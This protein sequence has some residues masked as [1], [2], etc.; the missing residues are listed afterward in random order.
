MTDDLYQLKMKSTKIGMI[1][2]LHSL[3]FLTKVKGQVMN[4][5]WFLRSKRKHEGMPKAVATAIMSINQTHDFLIR[6][7]LTADRSL[8]HGF[9][10]ASSHHRRS[11]LPNQVGGASCITALL[12]PANS[13]P[14]Y[15]SWG[16]VDRI[17]C[18]TTSG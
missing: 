1:L 14:R 8:R 9:L 10:T 6:Y 17:M 16:A 5:C 2:G 18:S 4:E 15:S 13:Q 7:A 12:N 11:D 3:L